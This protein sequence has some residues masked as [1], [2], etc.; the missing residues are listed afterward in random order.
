MQA[1]TL[2]SERLRAIAKMDVVQIEDGHARPIDCKRR[3][4]VDTGDGLG[5]WPAGRVQMSC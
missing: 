2:S 3:R 1:V 4:R 5:L